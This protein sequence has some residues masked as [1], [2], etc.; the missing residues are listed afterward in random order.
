M[1]SPGVDSDRT[2]HITSTAFCR[3][4]PQRYFWHRAYYVGSVGGA[5]LETVRR[6]VESQGTKEKTAQGP[7]ARL[8]PPDL[9][10]RKGNARANDKSSWAMADARSHVDIDTLRQHAKD[11]LGDDLL[12]V[13]LVQNSNYERR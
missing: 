4:I 7:A 12:S 3:K 2:G 11:F 13:T 10:P 1:D 5:T 9:R 8:T 6:Y